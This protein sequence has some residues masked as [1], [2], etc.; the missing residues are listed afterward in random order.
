MLTTKS[1]GSRADFLIPEGCELIFTEKGYFDEEA[2][3]K[4]VIFLLKQIPDDSKA[5]ILIMDGYGSHTMSSEVLM[6]FKNRNI[7]C[8][9]MPS[10]T[11]QAL[12]PLDVTCFGPTK[13]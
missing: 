3:V 5:R 10:H 6:L 2:F 11:S 13:R 8:I 7:H 1:A 4:Y 12:Q 9:C